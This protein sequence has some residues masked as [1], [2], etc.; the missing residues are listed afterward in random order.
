MIPCL[1]IVVPCYNEEE[2]I[3]SSNNILLGR[4]QELQDK[5]LIAK[6]SKILY[7]D[8]GSKDATWE[9]IIKMADERKEIC[10]VRLAKNEGHQNALMAGMK[11]AYEKADIVL[12][13][14]ADLQQDVNVIEQFL[15]KYAAGSDIVFGVRNSRDTDGIFK[16]M[17]ANIFYGLMK[18]LGTKTIRNH[19]DYRLMSHNALEALFEY[20]ETQLFL[21]GTVASM[22]FKTDTVYFDVKKRM[23]GKTSYS[24]GKMLTLAFSGITSFS[25][26]P[27][28]A[29]FGMGIITTIIGIAMIIYNIWVY[30]QGATVPGWT[31]ILC[32]LWFLGGVMLISQGII[33]EYVGKT[34]ME[35]KQRPLYFVKEKINID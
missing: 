27:I 30:I 13:I 14:D 11:A 34:Y 2:V 20:R 7:V 4:L 32:S 15:E 9:K 16:K 28:H 19:A 29:V 33:G 6:Q 23:A 18:L 8:D 10:A 1:Y 25:I 21:R 24:L 5:G 12:T 31:S 17:T 35:T 3:E 22:G 26:R